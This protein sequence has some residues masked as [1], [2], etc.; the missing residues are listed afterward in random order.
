VQYLPL[1]GFFFR[2]FW[3]V[4]GLIAALEIAS[5]FVSAGEPRD[6]IYYFLCASWVAAL[7]TGCAAQRFYA[8]T[9]N[10]YMRTAQNLCSIYA[11]SALT[12][13]TLIPLGEFDFRWLWF[14]VFYLGFLR[15]EPLRVDTEKSHVFY[16]LLL[17][18]IMLCAAYMCTALHFQIGGPI[19]DEDIHTVTMWRY[20][21]L[22]VVAGLYVVLLKTRDA[23]PLNRHIR[24]V[25]HLIALYALSLFLFREIPFRNTMVIHHWKA[26]V[27]SAA[28]L[29]DGGWL[30]WDV[31]SQYGFL[32]TLVV[33]ALPTETV[34]Q[35]LY[36]LNGTLL[37]LTGYM[38]FALLF[39]HFP[40]LIGCAFS[41]SMALIATTLL[42][43]GL[44]GKDFTN[45]PSG[46]PLRFFWVYAIA[47][48][49]FHISCSFSRWQQLPRYTV[50][51][52]IAL[53]LV[54]VLWSFE[55][56]VYVSI[57]WLPA[58]FIIS[59]AQA[60]LSHSPPARRG[61]AKYIGINFLWLIGGLL[62][63]ISVIVWVYIAYLGH[64]PDF[65][66]FFIYTLAYGNGFNA[67]SI[68]AYG[69]ISIVTY[70]LYLMV[71]LCAFVISHM[72]VNAKNILNLAVF[73]VAICG[74]W[75]VNSYYVTRS[76]DTII[77]S[78]LQGMILFTAMLLVLLK[79]MQVPAKIRKGFEQGIVLFYCCIVWLTISTSDYRWFMP[80]TFLNPVHDDIT[81]N[82]SIPD[83]FTKALAEA[84]GLPKN[85]RFFL[86]GNYRTYEESLY[87]RDMNFRPWML[88]NS[89]VNYA[90]PLSQEEYKEIAER[91]IL[92]L[93]SDDG[94]ILEKKSYDIV[95][96]FWIRQVIEKYYKEV[97]VMENDEYRIRKYEKLPASH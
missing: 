6:W 78:A 24:T 43:L 9:P 29:R 2:Y 75:L 83:Y 51:A 20:S 49:V 79:D 5:Y 8:I 30:L 85:A 91:R 1:P 19:K 73:Y 48:Y 39:T 31:P 45:F 70:V 60:F 15:F 59:V 96:V 88:P 77:Y 23:R 90:I 62:S 32:Q 69:G 57:L 84:A 4:G 27:E 26:F 33:A 55:S 28:S 61:F 65:R 11:L 47:L 42:M 12:Y 58:L 17:V 68:A 52:G 10:Y 87:F 36:L 72:T 95:N 13:Y 71:I 64:A 80:A 53:W 44:M 40:T 94:W 7:L 56:A 22:L 25:C 37:V 34:W 82:L 74:L 67:A 63:T 50:K 46:G 41:V 21:L 38:I 14:A 97:M 16:S 66:L 86:I 92:R 54:G 76:L 35:S 81:K 3:T 89:I 93:D 18:W